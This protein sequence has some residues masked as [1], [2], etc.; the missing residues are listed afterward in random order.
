MAELQME[1]TPAQVVRSLFAEEKRKRKLAEWRV[2]CYADVLALYAHRLAIATEQNPVKVMTTAREEVQ[3][4]LREKD[5]LG[6]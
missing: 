5:W 3:E 6:L 4:R 2:R 1:P